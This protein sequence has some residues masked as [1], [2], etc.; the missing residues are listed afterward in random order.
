[1][2]ENG[3]QNRDRPELVMIYGHDREI[4][5]WVGNQLD[6]NFEQN[7]VAIGMALKG[8]IIAGVVYHSYR[9]KYN[10]EMSIAAITPKWATRKTLKALFAY[11][12]MQLGLPRVTAVVS[13]KD[14]SVQ[15]FDERLGFKREGLMRDA[16]PDG[17][18]VIYGLLRKDCKYI[19]DSLNG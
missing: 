15:R 18:A 13:A 1:M 8:A 14:K 7:S 12:F 4:A 5:E 19:E 6:C 2:A 16:H 17:D 10:I 11:P 3:L 9:P